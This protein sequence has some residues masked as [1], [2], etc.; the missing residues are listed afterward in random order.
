MSGK[1]ASPFVRL[2]LAPLGVFALAS[3]LAMPVVGILGSSNLVWGEPNQFGRVR[4]PGTRVLTLPAGRIIGTVAVALP[5]R[6]NATPDL[7]LPDDLA[8]QIVPA[9]GGPGP[10]I[11]RHTAPT[12]N[13]MDKLDDTQRAVWRL[14]VPSAGKYRVDVRGSFLGIG[15]NPQLWL[16]HQAPLPGTDVPLVAAILGL[17]VTFIWAVS[18]IVFG[19]KSVPAT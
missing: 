7:P 3:F 4:I 17:V 12:G 16:G 6:G 9:G 18:R 2:V 15:L 14:D 13:A 1:A 11:T 5:G 10:A 19:R 8:L